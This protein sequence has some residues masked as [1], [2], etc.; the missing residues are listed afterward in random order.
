MLL[1]HSSVLETDVWAERR[2]NDQ[3]LIDYWH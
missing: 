3:L 2:G 1:V